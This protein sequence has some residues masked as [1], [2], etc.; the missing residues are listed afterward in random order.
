MHVSL[1]FPMQNDKIATISDIMG[2]DNTPM[3]L[4]GTLDY[5]G[6]GSRHFMPAVQRSRA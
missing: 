2:E 3:Q 6:F 5:A 4:A 1:F